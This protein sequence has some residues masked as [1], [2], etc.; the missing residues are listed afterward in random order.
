MLLNQIAKK[1]PNYYVIL[2]PAQRDDGRVRDWQVF[3]NGRNYQKIKDLADYYR[4]EGI[5]SAVII[6]TAKKGMDVS[7]DEAGSEEERKRLLRVLWNSTQMLF[8]DMDY[9]DSFGG[10]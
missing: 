7:P 2:A 1:Y 6:S 4:R 10:V 9:A 8:P 3:N 5:P